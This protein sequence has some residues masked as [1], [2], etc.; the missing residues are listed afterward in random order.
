LWHAENALRVPI[1]AL[2]RGGDGGGRVFVRENG[3]A[4]ERAIRIGQL[5]DEFSEVLA[6]LR[7]NEEVV[8]NPPNSLQDGARIRGRTP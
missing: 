3:R 8:V 2:F 6:G 7:E 1:G 5:N 4:R